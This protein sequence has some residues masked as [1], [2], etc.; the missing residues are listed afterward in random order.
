TL[1]S[2]LAIAVEKQFPVVTFLEALADE[3]GGRWRWKL[4][5]LADLLSAGISIPDAL[6]PMPGVLPAGAVGLVRIG[7]LSGN[8]SGALREAASVARRRSEHT[9]MRLQGTLLYLCVVLV[10]LGI[11]AAFIA[12]W[13]IPKFKVIFESFNSKLPPLTEAVIGICDSA[14]AYWYLI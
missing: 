14:G 8:L 5:G 9:G 11:I 10:V 3:A 6:E 2:T 1:L 4:R 12:I 13:I 7:A